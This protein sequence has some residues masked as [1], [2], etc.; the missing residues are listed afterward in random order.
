M[1][2]CPIKDGCPSA[3]DAITETLP[4]WCQRIT[5]LQHRQFE[6]WLRRRA[7]TPEDTANTTKSS[8]L[9]AKPMFFDYYFLVGEASAATKLERAERAE[10]ARTY[11]G[12]T[13]TPVLAQ[14]RQGAWE[15]ASYRSQYVGSSDFIRGY[16]VKKPKSWYPFRGEPYPWKWEPLQ[17]TTH[18]PCVRVSSSEGEIAIGNWDDP[19]YRA[20]YNGLK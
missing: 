17:A 18:F 20:R 12:I 7:S 14:P 11:Y 19:D 15:S 16:V 13:P 5:R 2:D 1:Y 9:S 6:E 8:L 4:L 10:F 3:A